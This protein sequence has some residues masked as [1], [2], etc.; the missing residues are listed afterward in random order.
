MASNRIEGE[1]LDVVL[2]KLREKGEST[3]LEGA[4]EFEALLNR[5]NAPHGSIDAQLIDYI[6]P[7]VSDGTIFQEHRAIQLLQT[8]REIVIG[9]N[10]GRQQDQQQPEDEE[11]EDGEQSGGEKDGRAGI[12]EILR[13]IDDEITRYQDVLA[14]RNAGIAA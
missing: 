5:P 12:G 11:G 2:Q 7:R 1:R 13:V 6:M 4:E 8:L 10:E 9:W 3:P 14:R